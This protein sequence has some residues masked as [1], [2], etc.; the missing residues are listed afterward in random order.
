MSALGT[1]PVRIGIDRLSGRELFRN[2]SPA[3]LHRTISTA[4]LV[5]VP[6]GAVVLSEGQPGEEV[7]LI[8]EGRAEVTRG[9]EHVATLAEGEL[10][11]EMAV[12][13]GG[14]RS[15]TVTAVTPI[16]AMAMDPR[17]LPDLPG[18]RA[19]AGAI[20]ASLIERLGDHRPAV[21]AAPAVSTDLQE[22]SGSAR[23]LLG[24]TLQVLERVVVSPRCGMFRPVT[25]TLPFAVEGEAVSTGQILGRVDNFGEETEVRSPFAGVLMGM[26]ALDGERVDEGQPIAWLRTF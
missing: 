1:K 12:V 18:T 8:L 3:E 22:P 13:S 5:S 19:I 2:C 24:E 14:R 25:V 17:A 7:F 6:S 10:F 9:G 4:R 15:A 26:L 20:L 11:G 16:E 23:A 21:A